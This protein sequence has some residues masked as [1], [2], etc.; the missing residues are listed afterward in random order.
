[1]QTTNNIG[2]EAYKRAPLPS[3]GS[4]LVTLIGF[5][6]GALVLVWIGVTH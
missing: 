4:V 6:G 3:V 2:N 1:M 5:L